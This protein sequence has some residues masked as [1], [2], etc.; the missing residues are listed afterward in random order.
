VNPLAIFAVQFLWFLLAWSLIAWVFVAPRLRGRD[1]HDALSV[2]VA[3]HLFRV[4]GLGL[5]VDQLSPGLSRDFALSTA[6]GDFVT[7][8]LA[9]ASLLALHMRWRPAIP[10][11]WT[12]N[13][14]G[15]GDLLIALP[16]A[17]RAEAALHMHAQWYVPAVGV[18][19]MLVAHFMIFH[20][21][22][23]RRTET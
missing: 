22:I 1:L 20:T 13:I 23:T 4:L 11:V 2:W 18:P 15:T 7:A 3:P 10:L 14:F 5:L 8:L 16:G 19:L 12:F 9:L 21:L 17:A 6:I